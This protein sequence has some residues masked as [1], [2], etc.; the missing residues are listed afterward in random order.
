MADFKISRIRFRWKGNWDDNVSYI[1]DDVVRYGGKTYVALVTHTSSPNF[2]T[3][4]EEVTA[5]IPPQPN[6]Y[7]ELMLDGYEWTSNWQTETFYQV[8]DLIKKNGIVYI[9]I[10]SHTS[11]ELETDFPLDIGLNYWLS[12][13]KTDNWRYDWT[14]NTSYSINDIIRYNGIVYRCINAHNSGTAG[15]N[16]TGLEINQNDWEQITD[17]ELWRGD[18][19]IDT[20]YRKND[21]VKYNGIVY[22]CTQGHP[23]A[24]NITDGLEYDLGK[25]TVFYENIEYKG[26]WSPSSIRYIQND[27]VKYGSSLYICIAPHTS[28]SIF[29]DESW[30]IYLPGFEYDNE[31]ISTTVYQKGDIVTYGGYNYYAK[32][33]NTN[34]VP[35]VES[36]DWE[37]LTTNYR[38]R[39]EYSVLTSYRVGD[40]VRRGGMLYVAIQDSVGIETTDTTYWELLIPGERWTNRWTPSQTY[41]IG[42]I[43]IYISTSYRCIIKHT[44]SYSNRPDIDT[45]NWTKLIEGNQANVLADIGDIKTYGIKEDGSSIGPIKRP[46]GVHGDVLAVED[47]ES[48]WTQLNEIT[49]VYYVSPEGD[50]NEDGLTM[51]TA[52]ATV[53]YACENITGP[54]TIFIKTGV[55]YEELPISI[56]ANVALVGDELRGTTIVAA[57]GFTSFNMFYVRD[58]SGIRN[59]TLKGLNGTLGVPNQW[60]TKRPSA[61]AYVSL[62][63]GAGVG[64]T[65]VWIQNRSPYIQNVTTFGTGCVGLKVDGGLHTG[66]NRS[67]VANDFTQV[68]SDGIGA[69]VTN[70][71]LS[72]LVSVFTYY[73]HIGYLSEFGGKIRG[74]N[75][76]CSY[77]TYGAVAE[78]FDPDESPIT[79]TINNRSEEASVSSV[80]CKAGQ[81][82]KLEFSNAGQNYSSA[83]ATF[84]GAG[85]GAIATFAEFRDQGVYQNRIY[86]P[87][88]SSAAG[89]GSYLEVQNNAQTGDLYSITIS[90]ADDNTALN[91]LGMRV[92]I[93]SGTGTGQYGVIYNF[94]EVTK[95]ASIKKESDDQ[96]GWDHVV[97][98]TPIETLLD[99]TTLYRIEPRIS[100]SFPGFT[101]TS[102]TNSASLAWIDVKYANDIYVA[103]AGATNQTSTSGSGLSWSSGGNLPSSANWCSLAV[104]DISGGGYVWVAISSG[105]T[106]A[107][108]SNNNGTSWN[109]ATLPSSG[110]WSAVEYGNN[111]FIAV[112]SGSTE[113]ALSLNGSTWSTIGSLPAGAN[114][115]SIAYGQGVWVAISTGG[116][117]AARSTDDGT[118]WS[119]VTMPASANWISIVYGNGRFVAIAN[120]SANTAYSFDGAT[121]YLSTNILSASWTKVAYGQGVFLAVATSNNA[122]SYSNDGNIWKSTGDDSTAFTLPSTSNW[123]SIAFGNP[124]SSGTWVAIVNG[125]SQA[126]SIKTGART[127]G[128]ATVRS[129]RVS[130]I[131]IL[132]PGSGY[133]TTPSISVYDPNKT[134]SVFVRIR[135]GNGVLANPIMTNSGSGYQTATTTATI[136][137]NGFADNYQTGEFLFLNNVSVVPGP[138]DNLNIAGINDLTYKIVTIQEL[139]GT[140]GN[141]SIR[142]SVSPTIGIE[143]SPDHAAT[144]EI[145]QRYSQVRLTG[146][147]F[148]DIGTGNFDDSNYP[149]IPQLLKAPENE[150]YEKDGGR[151]FYTSTDQDG[152]F[153]VGELFKVEQATG[154]VTISASLFQLSGLSEISL[155]GVSIGGTGVVIREFSTDS[156]FTAD[157][158]NIIP[159]QR[160]IKAYLSASISGGGSNALTTQFTAGIVRVG[161]QQLGTTT[162]EA[163]QFPTKVSINGEI[164]GSLLA[165]NYFLHGFMN[166]LDFD[167]D[168]NIYS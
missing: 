110:A 22:R 127:I 5:E 135:R 156:T 162:G 40:V 11:Q 36:D 8:G 116:T 103:I 109:S 130:N 94:D 37:L 29:D 151:C 154:T 72:E 90:A 96:G 75:G 79:G 146:H 91:Y 86:T 112:K 163:V 137:G 15:L 78:S 45:V 132:E 73:N 68:L 62:D 10:E 122:V 81:I 148:L 129:G 111:K 100:F 80:L 24:D 149:N 71:G 41:L 9:C 150:I 157:S 164:D 56:P 155:G 161:P 59:M 18:W 14:A 114:W 82:L 67:I 42:D 4:F 52:W 32:T 43:V 19:A 144:V 39:N 140:A 54:A 69:W 3:D 44:S 93:I 26:T 118:I 58:G 104:G 120:G 133:Q 70:S 98:G 113:T 106:D 13:T 33:N 21:L 49:K 97:P 126:A 101:A 92:F 138:G 124:S 128:R 7:W 55:Y 61:G 108:Y 105:G 57:P 60:G 143:E 12:Y 99:N 168:P 142:I 147:D 115:S 20:R 31:W 141:Y 123:T 84:A 119:V 117:Q 65:T 87:G 85:V 35:S 102:R 25:W 53:K 167:I 48:K 51:Q 1:K 159:T 153:R 83:N 16:G 6:P 95:L 47:G 23:S 77:G 38:I 27:I 76:N 2:Y 139:G 145:R 17:T 125:S 166:D 107:A 64:D 28:A 89:G 152:N 30:E 74:T 63:P 88:D 158:N 165:L 131:A 34:Q 46:I 50:N 121:W 136:S 134:S 160:A 66:G